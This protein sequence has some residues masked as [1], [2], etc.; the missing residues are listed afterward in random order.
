VSQKF[1][2]NHDAITKNAY[3][4]SILLVDPESTPIGRV[5]QATQVISHELTHQWF[6][7]IV[8][9]EWWSDLWLNEGFA[10]YFEFFGTAQVY[11]SN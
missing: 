4:E 7:N 9:P 6:G 11:A 2:S 1:K 10:T 8:S 3:S 5:Q